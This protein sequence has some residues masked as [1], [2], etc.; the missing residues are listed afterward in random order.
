[1]PT[2]S[3]HGNGVAVA[4]IALKS[5]AYTIDFL[6]VPPWDLSAYKYNDIMKNKLAQK[7]ASGSA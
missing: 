3:G 7:A 2:G 1:M 6:I 5:A 4:T